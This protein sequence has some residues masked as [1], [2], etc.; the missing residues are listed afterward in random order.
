[1]LFQYCPYENCDCPYSKMSKYGFEK[2]VAESCPKDES[3][4]EEN[5]ILDC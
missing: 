2:C 1:M 3:E 5:E 4:D